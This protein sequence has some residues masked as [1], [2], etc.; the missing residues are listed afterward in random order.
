MNKPHSVENIHQQENQK[1]NYNRS[2]LRKNIMYA[3]LILVY[4]GIEWQDIMSG[5][6]MILASGLYAQIVV[7]SLIIVHINQT[8]A[9][10][11]QYTVIQ[12]YLI[13]RYL[14]KLS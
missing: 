5:Y 3:M 10:L 9:I 2:L 14:P 13:T 11:T 8:A 12:H 1:G 4:L 7:H 6:C